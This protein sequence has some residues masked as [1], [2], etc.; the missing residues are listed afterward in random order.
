MSCSPS[1]VRN[2][3][4]CAA[5]AALILCRPANAR[6]EEPDSETGAASPAVERSPFLGEWELDLTRMPDTYGPPPKRVTFAF[7]DLGSGRWRTTVE[8]RAPDDSVRHIEIEYR[9][10]GRAVQAEGDTADGESAAL[11]SPAPNVL[12]MSQA[13]DRSLEGVRVYVVSA[14]GQEMTEAAANVDGSGVP[15]V[16]NFHFRRI[17]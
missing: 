15:F 7:E 8:I 2:L 16:R 14:D 4:F 3:F 1:P 5:A 6:P 12:V 9:R 17:R 11:I 13:R 10:D